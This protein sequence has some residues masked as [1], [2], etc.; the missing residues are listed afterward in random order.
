M[1]ASS[2]AMRFSAFSYSMSVRWFT[3][4]PLS[5]VASEGSTN[6]GPDHSSHRFAQNR[7]PR[8]VRTLGRGFFLSDLL[9]RVRRPEKVSHYIPLLVPLLVPGSFVPAGLFS[10]GR[11]AL[12]L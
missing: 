3:N 11:A 4:M 2:W 7:K 12:G 5:L 10:G 9:V 1:V 8:R 6:P